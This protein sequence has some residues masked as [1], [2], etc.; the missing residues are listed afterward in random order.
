MRIGL[1]LLASLSLV[2][3]APS[4]AQE[5]PANQSSTVP[6]SA[7]FEVVQSPL[8]AKLTLRLDRFSGE[9]WQFVETKNG[10]Y[11]WQRMPRINV[12]RRH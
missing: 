3:T 5:H 12:P 11:A 7:R 10:D 1:I 8:L 9:T 4:L 6:D 2:T